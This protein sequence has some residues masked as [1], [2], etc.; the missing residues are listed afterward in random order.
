MVV[1]GASVCDSVIA[2]G[3]G[4][5]EIYRKLR[6]MTFAAKREITRCSQFSRLSL[7]Q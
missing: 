5:P 7:D 1:M 3:W 4:A 2:R 6:V